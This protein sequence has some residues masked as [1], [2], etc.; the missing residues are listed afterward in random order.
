ML[1]ILHYAPYY[2]ANMN[3]THSSCHS[4]LLNKML[5]YSDTLSQQLILLVASRTA[6]IHTL[7]RLFN[8][9][10]SRF[11]SQALDSIL[12]HA[13]FELISGF[14]L[15]AC[16][17][18]KYSPRSSRRQFTAN[19]YARPLRRTSEPPDCTPEQSKLYA[20]RPALQHPLPS[21]PSAPARGGVAAGRR[22][23]RCSSCAWSEV[24]AVIAR[25]RYRNDWLLALP[26][27]VE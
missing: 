10:L 6:A 9:C 8:G 21:R 15:I 16:A 1:E 4:L 12:L 5:V 23:R 26:A 2:P 18:L 20:E 27:K 14:C 11:R 19:M 24:A 7:R 3:C 25:T 22:R 17:E 13:V